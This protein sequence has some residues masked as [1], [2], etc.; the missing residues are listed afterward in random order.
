MNMDPHDGEL[1]SALTRSRSDDGFTRLNAIERLGQLIAHAE[2]RHRLEEVAADDE[3]VTMQVDAAEV[4]VRCGGRTGLLAVL[5]ILGKR[6][7]D[8]DADYIANRLSDL[9]N[10]GQIPVLSIALAID[11][12]EFSDDA[13]VGLENLRILMHR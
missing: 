8:P 10:L 9:D 6:Q 12:H 7:E 1:Q 11:S 3:L 2:A 4:L 13:R 5:E